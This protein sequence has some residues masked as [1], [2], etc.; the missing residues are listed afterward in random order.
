MSAVARIL[1]R[2][3]SRTEG[4]AFC[5]DDRYWFRPAYTEGRCPL[6]GEA[7]P[8]GSSSLPRLARMDRS[9]LGVGALALE[10]LAMIALVLY[11][12]FRG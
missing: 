1:P 7:A 10:S 6:C 2:P 5:P 9:W 11:L 4:Y 3:R 12:Y 8:A